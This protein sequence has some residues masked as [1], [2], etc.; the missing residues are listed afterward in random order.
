MINEI[1]TRLANKAA[2]DIT[3]W[4]VDPDFTPITIPTEVK[5]VHDIVIGQ[6]PDKTVPQVMSLLKCVDIQEYKSVFDSRELFDYLPDSSIYDLLK[7]VDASNTLNLLA[8]N[9]K[10][11][12][13]LFSGDEYLVSLFKLYSGTNEGV[14]KLCSVILAIAYRLKQAQD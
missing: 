13:T 4:Y 12:Y 7:N 5:W 11:L 2:S 6:D 1:P 9:R 14:V 3:A 10:P 8:A